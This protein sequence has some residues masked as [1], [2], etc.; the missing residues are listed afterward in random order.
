[1]HRRTVRRYVATPAPPRNRPPERSKPSGLSSP[2]LQPFVEYLQ[3]PWQAGCANVAQLKRELNA[4]GYTGSYSLLMQAL[5][6]WCG[7][8]PPRDLAAGGGAADHASNASTS[9]GCAC[10]HQNN[11]IR[12]NTRRLRRFCRMTTGWM[13]ATSYSSDS[14]G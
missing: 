13:L 11:S 14:V 2:T 1:M 4:Q 7:P 8:R 5:Q 10:V 9:A 12:M 6:P 3:G